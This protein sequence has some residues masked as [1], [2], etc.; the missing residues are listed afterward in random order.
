MPM[1]TVIQSS[2]STTVLWK[3]GEFLRG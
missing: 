2:L 1:R 3:V